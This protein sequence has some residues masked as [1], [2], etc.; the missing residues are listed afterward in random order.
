MKI[1][2]SAVKAAIVLAGVVSLSAC[3]DSDDDKEEVVPVMSLH[4]NLS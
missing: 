4:L 1:K 2:K 3:F